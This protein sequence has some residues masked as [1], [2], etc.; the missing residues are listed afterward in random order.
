MPTVLMIVSDMQFST[1]TDN[2]DDIVIEFCLKRWDE[3]GYDRPRIL[4][5]NTSTFASSQATENMDN[6]G[7]ISG[8]S[9]SILESVFA[10]EEFTPVAIMNRTIR[11]YEIK[12]P[13]KM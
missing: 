11:K 5:W 9:P 6:V 7:M 8:F 13:K 10:G 2:S 4:F 1:C 12:N 3:A